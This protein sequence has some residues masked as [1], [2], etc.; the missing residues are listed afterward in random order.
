MFEVSAPGSLMVCGEHAVLEG[1]QAIVAAI[2]QRLCC[3]FVAKDDGCVRFVS[4]LGVYSCTLGDWQMDSRFAFALQVCREVA[5]DVAVE[6]VIESEIDPNRG[7]ASSA[8]LVVALLAGFLRLQGKVFSLEE[9]HARALRV[10]RI[11]Q[12]RGSGADLAAAVYGGF[13]AYAYQEE[14]KVERLP[15]PDFLSFVRYAG[16]KRKTAEVI[17]EVKALYQGREDVLNALYCEMGRISDV[18]IWALKKGDTAKFCKALNA[19]QGLMERL[20]VCDD[21]QKQH[22]Q[23]GLL[24]GAQAIK[25]SGSGLGDCVLAFAKCA[26]SEGFEQVF[27]STQG[28]LWRSLEQANDEDI[29]AEKIDDNA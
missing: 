28:V 16:Y 25:I 19:Y 11:V 9:L 13:L 20:G 4:A 5:L 15:V 14:A 21:V 29:E 26:L 23:E 8:A 12:G 6:V 10:V 24:S 18:A 7:F 1:H 2:S 27:W 17:A 3:R 22:V